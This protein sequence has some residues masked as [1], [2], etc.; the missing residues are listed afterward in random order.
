MTKTKL[1][2][3]MIHHAKGAEVMTATQV[4][5]FLGVSDSFKAKKKYLVGLEAIDG[6]YYLIDEVADVLMG[7][8]ETA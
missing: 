8:R 3:A 7:R 4:A 2:R 1:K 6:K 5:S